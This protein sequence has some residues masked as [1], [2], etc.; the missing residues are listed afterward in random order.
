MAGN[1]STGATITSFVND[2]V[3]P[4]GGAV[5]VNGVAATAAG[6]S[7]S[8]SSTTFTIGS[9]TDYTDASSG[10]A[11]SVLTVQSA[12]LSGGTCGAAGSGGPFTNPTTITGTTQPSGIVAGACYIYTLAGTDHVGNTASVST[13]VKVVLNPTVTATTPTSLATGASN[14]NIVITGTGFVS[15]SGLAASFSGTGV[16]VNSTTFNSST[17]VTANVSVSTGA[18]VGPRDVTVT[19]PD[20]GA[21]TC[22]SCFG[23]YGLSDVA[24]NSANSGKTVSTTA[25]NLTAGVP[26]LMFVSTASATGDSATVSFSKHWTTDPTIT[27]I[28]GTQDYNGGVSHNWAWAL[29]GGSGSGTSGNGSLT[30]TLSNTTTQAYVEVV[31]VN[32][33]MNTAAGFVAT[34]NL[35]LAN[36]GTTL[37][38]T[39]TAQLPGTPSNGSGEIIFWSGDANNG[40]S[41]PTVGATT[42]YVGAIT[43]AYQH[44]GH[45][46]EAVYGGGAG[47][48]TVNLT[49]TSMHWGTIALEVKHS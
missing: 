10:L 35:G 22:S 28:G 4:T 18:T 12:S 49:E 32:G 24:S 5:T 36:S 25:F 48:A 29:T 15:G 33:A 47:T 42:P 30:I 21:G 39:A 16:T 2:T 38:T 11:S 37:S 13:T 41:A 17:Q 14:Q 23:V 43:A 20:G 27:A 31:A 8:S 46:S 1:T 26:Y 9:R 44:G 19:N 34:G 45:G 3:A 6:S 40:G 7:S